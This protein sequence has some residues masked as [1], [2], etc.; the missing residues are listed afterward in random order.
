MV[1]G[2]FVILKSRITPRIADPN[3]HF[4]NHYF[5]K[6]LAGGENGIETRMCVVTES[7]SKNP[8]GKPVG[9][10]N[11]VSGRLTVHQLPLPGQHNQVTYQ[12]TALTI[13]GA[14]LSPTRIAWGAVKQD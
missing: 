12:E 6:R 3:E 13:Y 7:L 10:A 9:G 14:C 1:L 11:F 5:T 4:V 8:T 2:S